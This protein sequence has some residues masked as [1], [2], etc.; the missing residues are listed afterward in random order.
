MKIL[1]NVLAAV[2]VLCAIL[3]YFLPFGSNG[4]NKPVDG[5]GIDDGPQGDN[6]EQE[7]ENNSNE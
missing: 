4:N 3:V 7:P 1:K 2:L 5:S 6:V